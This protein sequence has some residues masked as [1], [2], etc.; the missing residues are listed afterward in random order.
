MLSARIRS[1]VNQR[2]N[3]L[4]LTHWKILFL[5]AE[6][7]IRFVLQNFMLKVSIKLDRHSPRDHHLTFASFPT[8]LVF[9]FLLPLTTFVHELLI[10]R[11]RCKHINYEWMGW[12]NLKVTGAHLHYTVFVIPRFLAPRQD[13]WEVKNTVVQYMFANKYLPMSKNIHW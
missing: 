12:L 11:Q 7:E 3:I 2:A 8:S 5:E 9:H 1:Q 6:R 4:L 10:F 13:R